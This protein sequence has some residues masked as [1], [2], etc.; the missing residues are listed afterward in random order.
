MCKNCGVKNTKTKNTQNTDVSIFYNIFGFLDGLY[1]TLIK[2]LG[3]LDR[4]KTLVG[5][6]D[7]MKILY[8]HTDRNLK[9]KLKQWKMKKEG[10]KHDKIINAKINKMIHTWNTQNKKD[11]LSWNDSFKYFSD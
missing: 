6:A 8:T 4:E 11:V 2:F 10:I 7:I 3:D 1:N 5:I 9:L